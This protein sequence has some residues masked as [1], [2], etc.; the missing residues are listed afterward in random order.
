MHFGTD[1]ETPHSKHSNKRQADLVSE[2]NHP[3]RVD[4]ALDILLDG[5]EAHELAA[6]TL[7]MTYNGSQE[8]EFLST[9]AVGAMIELLLVYWRIEV[10]VEMLQRAISVMTQITFVG[11]DLRVPSFGCCRVGGRARP[12]KK[13]L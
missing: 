4:D 1:Y 12:G 11:T 7:Q 5:I 2:R 13:L 6:L 10:L 3:A 9:A 8:G